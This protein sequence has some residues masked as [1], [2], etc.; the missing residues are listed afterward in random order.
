M[1]LMFATILKTWFLLI[2]IATV[3]LFSIAQAFRFYD[4]VW[5]SRGGSLITVL[6]LLLTVKH[7]IFSPGRDLDSIVNEKFHYAVFAPSRGDA[8]W[9]SDRKFARKIRR[10]ERLG[11]LMTIIGT[12]VW[13]YGDL[14]FA[15]ILQ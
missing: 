2:A 12:I 9:E 7:S 11:I 15:P 4:P 3:L 5:F 13:G 14:I 8:K 6:G 1:E 10:D